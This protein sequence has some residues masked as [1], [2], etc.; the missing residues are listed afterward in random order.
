M[1]KIL[2]IA[3]SYKD[4]YLEVTNK[5]EEY[6]KKKGLLC[7]HILTDVGEELIVPARHKD[8]EGFIVLGGDG[9]FIHAAKQAA[10]MDVPVIG[11]NLGTLGYLCELEEDTLGEAIDRMLSD[12]FDIEE[13]M[14]L[15]GVIIDNG[16]VKRKDV[17]INDVVIHRGGNLRVLNFIIYVNGEHLY[18]YTADGIIISTPTGS[19]GYSMSAGGPIV[20]PSAKLMVVTPI[21]PHILNGKSI[22]LSA[23][24]E[25]VIEIGDGRR[26]EKEEALVTFDGGESIQVYSRDKIYVSRGEKSAKILKLNNRSFLKTLSKKMQNYS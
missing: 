22:I 10:K 7:D 6:A 1:K 21:N 24:D 9:T 4:T 11:F 17:A 14:M 20:E 3:N 16:E 15:S 13:R 5:I 19:T 25:V 2:V 23:N 12:D 26:K 8:C 18:T